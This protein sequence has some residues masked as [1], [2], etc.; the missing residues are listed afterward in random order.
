MKFK[1]PQYAFVLGS[2]GNVKD[3]V[4][5]LLVEQ[6][7][8]DRQVFKAMTT[9]KSLPLDIRLQVQRLFET[10]VPRDSAPNRVVNR[11]VLTGRARGVQRFARLSRIMLRQL[12]HNGFLPGV[13]KASW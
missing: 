2:R 7:E 13:A 6:H 4:R 9:D 10:E 1:L 11:C 8:V 3:H 12:A 5:R